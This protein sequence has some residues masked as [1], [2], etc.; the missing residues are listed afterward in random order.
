MLIEQFNKILNK[1]LNSDLYP[2]RAK[3]FPAYSK[4]ENILVELFD[5]ENLKGKKNTYKL[6]NKLR[7]KDSLDTKELAKF[8]CALYSELEPCAPKHTKKAEIKLDSIKK[9]NYNQRE[10]SVLQKLNS[11]FEGE[12]LDL[13]IHGSY[14]DGDYLKGYSD[15]DTII[16]ARDN[17]FTPK[18]LLKA[19]KLVTETR[20]FQYRID[21]LQHHGHLVLTEK[22]LLNYP[23]HSFLPLDTFRK[24]GATVSETKNLT[25]NY[26]RDQKKMKS[27]FLERLDNVKK[28]FQRNSSSLYYQKIKISNLLLMPALFV[29]A[30][31][32]Y[33]YKKD[34]FDKAEEYL[35]EESWSSI[36]YA[37]KI[38]S[39]WPDIHI[40]PIGSAVF[41][42]FH[43][44]Y[45]TNY[46]ILR[47]RVFQPKR[48]ITQKFKLETFELL[49]EMKNEI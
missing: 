33:L 37:S 22:M 10:Y 47:D 31:G 48:Y 8:I 6:Y 18:E 41:N 35:S 17:V 46:Y 9:K 4:Q 30:K 2:R 34:S 19:R 20:Y 43:P 29:Q 23:E 49:E 44:A 36:E 12:N 32:D 13:I 11:R 7:K 26:F 21:G 38:R 5:R 16:I 1:F 3:F 39:E 45:P 14:G 15:L 42:S 25:I 27:T 28:S 24:S 40:P